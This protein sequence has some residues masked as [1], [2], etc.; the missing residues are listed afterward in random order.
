MALV[1][2]RDDQNI[3][4]DNYLFTKN[5]YSVEIEVNLNN[6]LHNEI[7]YLSCTSSSTIMDMKKRVEQIIGIVPNL[8]DFSLQENN[9]KIENNMQLIEMDK[10]SCYISNSKV[11]KLQL[12]THTLDG[13]NMKLFTFK[14]SDIHP[15]QLLKLQK[16]IENGFAKNI[17]PELKCNGSGGAYL[18]RDQY[19]NPIG[20]FKPFNEEP[21]TPMN[22]HKEYLGSVGDTG[23]HEG[24]KSGEGYLREV[25][26][27]LIDLEKGFHNVP[28]T[29]LCSSK[30]E[31][32]NHM[33]GIND[34]KIGSLQ[35]Y[36]YHDTCMSDYSSTNIDVSEVHKIGILDIRILNVDRNDGNLLVTLNPQEGTNNQDKA[37]LIPIDHGYCIPNK[38][39]IDTLDW[40]WYYWSQ[41][42]VKFSKDTLKYINELDID[43]DAEMLHKVLH[44]DLLSL[45]NIKI[46]GRLL[47]IGAKHG[48]TLYD[49][50][51]WIAK[52]DINNKPTHLEFMISDALYLTYQD[53]KKYQDTTQS[54]SNLIFSDDEEGSCSEIYTPCYSP[55][56]TGIHTNICA[57]L[58]SCVTLSNDCFSL[59][60]NES[61]HIECKVVTCE[62]VFC[63]ECCTKTAPSSPKNCNDAYIDHFDNELLNGLIFPDL[64]PKYMKLE[65]VS[66]ELWELDNGKFEKLFFKNL[67]KVIE[68]FLT[69]IKL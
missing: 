9:W 19:N 26:A 16:K 35:E 8:Q 59:D 1:S 55:T 21:Y 68:A 34:E 25:A 62:E 47:K 15:I 42:K 65:N 52:G 23:L 22:P 14:F 39:N 28:K 48:F 67:E 66:T 57:P 43:G 31:A 13:S 60:N 54:I 45:R 30:H 40:C 63:E 37:L 50:A 4:S 69:K 2:S 27:Y 32:Y 17:K 58:C 18:L 33:N 29:Y 64:T 5:F 11:L 38:M 12:N 24:I 6:S 46:S 56:S 41:S 20:F 61:L 10:F 51:S 44:I 3:F 7:I 53:D 36:I 49:I